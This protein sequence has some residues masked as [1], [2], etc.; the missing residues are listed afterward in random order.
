MENIH[1]QKLNISNSL[2]YLFRYLL[3]PYFIKTNESVGYFNS[4]K[5]LKLYDLLSKTV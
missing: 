5:K 2:L 1:L 3:F 4:V